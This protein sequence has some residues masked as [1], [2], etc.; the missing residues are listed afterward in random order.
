MKADTLWLPRILVNATWSDLIMV[1]DK[2]HTYLPVTVRS[3]KTATG[4][5]ACS[6][7]KVI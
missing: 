6:N 2:G 4:Q 5:A 3:N 7:K 1:S